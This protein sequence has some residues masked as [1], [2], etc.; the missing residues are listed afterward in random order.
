MN[1]EIKAEAQKLVQKSKEQLLADSQKIYHAGIAAERKLSAWQ[2][3]L[4]G[5]AIV[6]L[7]GLVVW[8]VKAPG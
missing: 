8:L 6:A 3:W 4:L 5:A 7:V 2:K 1:D